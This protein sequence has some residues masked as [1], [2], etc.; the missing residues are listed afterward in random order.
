MTGFGRCMQSRERVRFRLKCAEKSKPW[1]TRGSN[2]ARTTAT[3]CDQ[4]QAPRRHHTKQ[5]DEPAVARYSF[6]MLGPIFQREWLTLPRRGQHYLTRTA[7]LGLLWVLGLTTWQ[8][9]IGWERPATLGSTA[10][11]GLLLFQVLAYLQLVL[12]L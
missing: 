9:L 8:A 4:T 12:L 10:R 5:L 2:G 11:F 1:P 7:Y 3:R 6:S